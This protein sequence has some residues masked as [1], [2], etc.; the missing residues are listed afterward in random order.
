MSGLHRLASDAI[1]FL[2]KA[3]ERI[4]HITEDGEFHGPVLIDLGVVDVDVDDRSVLA[5]LL[6]LAGH[7]VVETD[8]DSQ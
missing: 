5:E 4:L 8:A 6:H 7:A 1:E 3:G 2:V